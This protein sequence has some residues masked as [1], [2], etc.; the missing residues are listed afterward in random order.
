MVFMMND[1]LFKSPSVELLETSGDSRPLVQFGT[2]VGCECGTAG[3]GA[4][5]GPIMPGSAGLYAAVDGG[6]MRTASM[7]GRATG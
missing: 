5:G 4:G 7:P 2:D 1:S 3:T 6:G